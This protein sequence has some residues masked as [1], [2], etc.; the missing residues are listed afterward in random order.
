MVDSRDL[1]EDRDVDRRNYDEDDDANDDGGGDDDG[2]D[3]YYNDENS[4]DRNEGRVNAEGG[5]QV[6]NPAVKYYLS[7]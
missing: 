2:D 4:L 3:D 1:N 6:I 5:S 7:L